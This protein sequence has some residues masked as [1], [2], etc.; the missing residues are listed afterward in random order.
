LVKYYTKN[1]SEYRID[2][3]N[4]L[5]KN[6]VLLERR[7]QNFEYIGITNFKKVNNE[8]LKDNLNNLITSEILYS[9][10]R[11]N[12]IEVKKIKYS[13]I[14]NNLEIETSLVFINDNLEKMIISTPITCYEI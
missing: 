3:K 7:N 11:D 4:N 6:N 10:F 9:K 13:E 14:L 12:K 8:L 1:N 5:I 2:S